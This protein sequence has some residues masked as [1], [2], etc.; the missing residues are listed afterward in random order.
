VP[1]WYESGARPHPP[2]SMYQAYLAQSQVFVGIYW[3]RYG[4]IAPGMEI[5]GLEDEY[6]LAAGKPMLLCLKRPAPDQEPRMQ[7]FSGASCSR[8]SRS[9]SQRS[10]DGHHRGDLPAARRYSPRH[11]AGSGADARH[12]PVGD[13]GTPQRQVP[14]AHQPQHALER[15]GWLAV[16]HGDFDTGASTAKQALR[17]AEDLGGQFVASAQSLLGF[18]ALQQGN[19][20]LAG[21]LL[22]RSLRNARAN[23]DLIG[24]AQVR[25][26]QAQL[27]VRTGDPARAE[28]LL[29]EVV[30]IARQTGDTGLAT[31]GLLSAIPLLVDSGRIADAR[32]RWLTAYQQTG[33]ADSAVLQLALLG[34]AA[35]IAAARGR[36]RQAVV[37]TEIAL[38]LLS[39]TGW[40]D[41]TLLAWFWRTVAPAYETL[42]E[43]DVNGARE[44]G[45]RKTLDAALSYAASDDD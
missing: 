12:D 36:S 31:Y 42:G 7:A 22:A 9:A 38:G 39:E 17:L 5:S 19:Q 15:L 8:P 26:H 43:T 29:D 1:V 6:R 13:P 28:E 35:A 44:E 27:A 24:V 40:R 32:D 3:Q 18:T 41:D 30:T 20:T 34:Y 10:G 2:R 16:E 45:Q 37:L 25:H 21:R 33:P 11:R 14:A 23:G 4:W